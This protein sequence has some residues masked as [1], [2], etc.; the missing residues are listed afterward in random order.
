MTHEQLEDAVIDWA[1]DRGIFAHST[2]EAQLL[3][4]ISE[5]GELADA[6]IKRDYNGQVDAVGD[7]LVCLINYCA[8]MDLTPTRCLERAYEAIKHRKG[9]MVPGGAFIKDE[10]VAK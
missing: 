3:K 1:E 5:V 4:A 9:R 10:E 8:F 2:P 7:V 6:H